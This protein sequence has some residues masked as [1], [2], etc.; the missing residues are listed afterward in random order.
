MIIYVN[1]D[2][3]NAGT[4]LADHLIFEECPRLSKTPGKGFVS[5]WS[6]LRHKLIEKRKLHNEIEAANKEL[7]WPTILGKLTG[8]TI[9]NGS[10]GGSAFG[11]IVNRTI[12]DIE[13]LVTTGQIPDYIFIGITSPERVMVINTLLGADS[14]SWTDSAIPGHYQHLS[15]AKQKYV[16]SVWSSHSNDELL[17]MFLRECLFI[18]SF[19]KVKTGKDPIFLNTSG[20]WQ[21]IRQTIENTNTE[22]IRFLWN[23]LDFNSVF[24][25]H[26]A[27]G[28]FG[29]RH[30]MCA[31]GHWTAPAH[32]D[33]ANYI[34]TTFI[35]ENL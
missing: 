33:Y 20:V 26:K 16:Q 9:V 19:V 7:V 14:N 34:A 15:R 24:F 28:D 22:M 17:A 5:G 13:H 27:F 6:E 4:G 21:D 3:F 10:R 18:K 12:Y 8:A 2:S 30:P 31:D 11:G 23:L 32:I 1:G 29:L 35:K 25:D